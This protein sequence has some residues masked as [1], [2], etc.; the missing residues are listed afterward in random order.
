MVRAF[1]TLTLHELPSCL[2]SCD[3]DKALEDVPDNLHSKS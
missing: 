2:S 1:V 3:W